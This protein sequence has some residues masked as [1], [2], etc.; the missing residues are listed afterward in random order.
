MTVRYCSV[1]TVQVYCTAVPIFIVLFPNILKQY[2][3]MKSKHPQHQKDSNNN[4]AGLTRSAWLYMFLLA[5]QFGFQPILTKTFTPAT[6]CRSS[7]VIV[8]ESIKFMLAGIF[9]LAS[10]QL[11]PAWQEW[12]LYSWVHVAVLPATL[13]CIQNIAA[14]YAYQNLDPLT[15]NVLNQTKTLSAAFCCYL[16]MGYK[17]SPIQIISLFLLLIS[18]LILENIIPLQRQDHHHQ[19]HQHTAATT[20]HRLF[21]SSHHF[22]HGVAPILVASFLSGLNGAITQKSL[23]QNYHRTRHTVTSTSR[24]GRGGGG[25]RNSYLFSMELC[26]ASV[27][28][29]LASLTVSEDGIQI[30]QQGFFHHWTIQT[31]I[32]I[33]TNALGGIIVGLVTKHAGSVQKGFAL[34]FGILISGIVQQTL[35]LEPGIVVGNMNEN[36]DDNT[37]R[38]KGTAITLHQMVSG[39]LAAISLW[40]HA[41]YPYS[42]SSS[43]TTS[44]SNMTSSISF[45]KIP[46]STITNTSITPTASA[47]TSTRTPARR[48]IRKED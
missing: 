15:F 21:F 1:S 25:G 24:V 27:L 37:L 19:Q 30:M 7:V 29:L 40:M 45:L 35:L 39:F 36:E 31:F 14:L 48:K 42:S 22:T 47:T 20:I 33:F 13:Y 44:T 2:N 41:A 46:T 4:H 9:L 28:I 10:G 26:V 3:K 11:Y 8:Q 32:P 17:Q 43:T 16:I 18:T 23:Q 34:I 6:V 5:L 12:S 38:R